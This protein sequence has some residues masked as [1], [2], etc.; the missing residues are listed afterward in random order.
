MLTNLNVLLYT[1]YNILSLFLFHFFIL[2]FILKHFK[3]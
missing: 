1:M 2:N 3:I